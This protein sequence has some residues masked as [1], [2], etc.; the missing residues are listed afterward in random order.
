MIII[1]VNI[2]HQSALSFVNS[3][4]YTHSQAATAPPARPIGIAI[5]GL[6]CT[7]TYGRT[8]Y[9]VIPEP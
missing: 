8:S 1:D 5:P 9:D 4:S 3:V 6:V 2:N 7:T